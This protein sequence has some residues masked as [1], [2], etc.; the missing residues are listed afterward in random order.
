MHGCLFIYKK[1]KVKARMKLQGISAIFVRYCRL[2][3]S[4][5]N[6]R[7]TREPYFKLLVHLFSI[8]IYS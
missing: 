3:D 8:Q 2:V 1:M 4:R 7:L 5:S 6:E